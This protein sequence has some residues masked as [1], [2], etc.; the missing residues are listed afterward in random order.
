M[1]V[2]KKPG[3]VKVFCGLIYRE[4]NLVEEVKKLLSEKW[5]GIDIEAGPFPFNFTDYYEKEMGKDLKRRFFGFKGFFIPEKVWEWKI[6][7]NEIEEKFKKEGEYPRR[8][9]LDPGYIDLSKVVLLS[10]KDY[11]H[12]IYI[13]KG[14]YAE[15]TLFYQRGDYRF[16]PWTYPDYKTDNYLDFFRKLRKKFLDERSEKKI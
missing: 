16:F 13:G 5:G 4:E 12:R 3:E 9:N 11:Y 14:I 7:T 15:V 1:G 8:I 6:F 2:I 10:T